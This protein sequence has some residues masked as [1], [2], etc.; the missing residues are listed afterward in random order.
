MC[1]TCADNYITLMK[2]IKE[3]G[4]KWG[5][6]PCLRIKRLKEIDSPQTDMQV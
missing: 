2:E 5:G 4:I 1:K 3:D 6:I